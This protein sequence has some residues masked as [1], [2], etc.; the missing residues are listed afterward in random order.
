M[1]SALLLENV[2]FCPFC[3]DLLWLFLRL[4]DEYSKSESEDT[5]IPFQVN[6]ISVS[7]TVAVNSFF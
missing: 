7:Q 6:A 5:R 1:V 3:Y 2:N 4:S